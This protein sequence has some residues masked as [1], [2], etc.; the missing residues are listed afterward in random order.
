M[1]ENHYFLQLKN[2]L[3]RDNHLLYL[4]SLLKRSAEL[5]S[6]KRALIADD[7]ELSYEELYFRAI[8]MSKQLQAVGV[9][10]GDR[11]IIYYENSAE[12]VIAYFAVLQIGAI[13]VPINTFLHVRE[14]AYV[15]TD[16]SPVLIVVSDTFS[17]QL[18]AVVSSDYK[19]TLPLLITS[20][21]FK[22]Q[23]PFDAR[24]INEFTVVERD[25]HELAVL[26]YT[27]GTTGVPKGVMLSSKNALTNSLQ[28]YARFKMV[29]LEEGERIF[30][31]LPLFHVFAQNAC[32]WFP[33]L[34][35]STIILVKKIDRKLIR[36]ALRHKPTLFLGFPALYGL[37]CLM[38]DADLESVKLFISGADML[39]DKIRQAFA[40]IYG[41]KIASGYGL[42]EASP[43]VA[44]YYEEDDADTQTVGFPVA[45]LEC[46]ILDES[47]L[48]VGPHDVGTL[49]IKGDNVMLGYYKSK[50]ETD[51]VLRDGWLNTGDLAAFTPRG[52][53]AIRGRSK[54]L[55][56]HKGFNIYPAEVEN[57]LLLHPQ[58]F[59]AA[60]V[61]Q[62]DEQTGQIPIAFVAA[63]V[64]PQDL[65]LHLQE[66]CS[67]NLAAY[68]IPR[69]IICLEDLPMSPTGKIDKKRLIV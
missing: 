10:P 52:H 34:A 27:S 55:I 29:G 22:W 47:G 14:L 31:V 69:K 50:E 6:K 51:R 40:L 30:C 53:L 28:C 2:E 54:D 25:E 1:G 65:E 37:L 36:D 62:W 58:V 3:T 9:V 41:R 13:V 46:R 49:W 17:E 43:V 20:S 24:V 21:D 8:L 44:V 7:R 16:A 39:P 63:K 66:L 64:I 4:G 42:S 56:I 26:L 5:Y 15:L 38:R 67:K 32:L 12:F 60:V 48:P 19:V 33:I 61:G 59:K 68:K 23:E 57:I 35:G 11:V 18:A 45:G